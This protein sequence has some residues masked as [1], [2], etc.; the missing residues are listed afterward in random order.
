MYEGQLLVVSV[1][2]VKWLWIHHK[3][4][5]SPRRP[6]R[7]NYLVCSENHL[8][9][10]GIGLIRDNEL[11]PPPPDQIDLVVHVFMLGISTIR[12]ICDRHNLNIIF[13]ILYFGQFP[14]FEH[15]PPDNIIDILLIPSLYRWTLTLSIFT[16]LQYICCYNDQ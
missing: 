2:Q 8:C 3:T 7:S 12:Y 11:Y 1:W 16:Y 5:S 4:C 10:V 15:F 14:F 9:I 13:I 6:L